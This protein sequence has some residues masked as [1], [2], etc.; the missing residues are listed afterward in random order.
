MHLKSAVLVVL[1]VLGFFCIA[2]ASADPY[3]TY[4]A[5]GATNGTVPTDNN[6]YL[7]GDT[8]TV[9]GNIGGLVKTGYNFNGWNTAADGSGTSYSPGGTFSMGSEDVTLYARWTSLPP[10]PPGHS[11]HQS[12]EEIG[13]D[14]P[15]YGLKIAM[16]NFDES[17]TFNQSARLEKEINHADLRL[18]ELEKSLSDNNTEAVN[19]TLALYWEKFNQTEET[20]GRMGFNSTWNISAWNISAPGNQYIHNTIPFI[21]MLTRH[22]EAMKNLMQRY[23]G[24]GNLR[25]TYDHFQNKFGLWIQSRPGGSE[26]GN[27]TPYG[28]QDHG[29][30]FTRQTDQNKNQGAN[31]EPQRGPSQPSDHRM[32]NGNPMDHSR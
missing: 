28:E 10:Y 14:N 21:N 3:D 7:S 2:V 23:P 5:N 29:P 6:T 26:H 15:F 13:P 1:L 24:R 32:G 8:V 19:R 20:L 9:L 30:N 11:E 27:I 25:E 18:S 31:P 22:E 17:F 4:N 12:F 16:E